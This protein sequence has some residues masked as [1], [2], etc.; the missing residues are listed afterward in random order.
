[1]ARLFNLKVFEGWVNGTTE[2]FSDPALNGTLGS[3]DELFFQVNTDAITGATPALTVRFLCSNDG[4]NWDPN[5]TV[6][7]AASQ[8]A[9]SVTFGNSSMSE[10]AG[11]FGR[12]GAFTEASKA[13][14]VRIWACGR[15]R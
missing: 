6:V 10:P 5:A 7:S 13:V 1:M 9:G 3:A 14:Y 2:L 12:I 11:G 8:S 15:T 4:L